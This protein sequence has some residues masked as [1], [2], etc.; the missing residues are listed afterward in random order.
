MRLR[1]NLESR[2]AEEIYDNEKKRGGMRECFLS[3]FLFL[4]NKNVLFTARQITLP[5]SLHIPW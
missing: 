3:A 1:S 2:W 4:P 5:L